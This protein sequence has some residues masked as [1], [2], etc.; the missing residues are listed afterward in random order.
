MAFTLPESVLERV[1]RRLGGRSCCVE[2]LDPART[3]LIV[4]DMQNY[5]VVPGFQ[6][7]CDDARGLV[8]PIHRLAGELR[9]C[10]GTVAWIQTAALPAEEGDWQALYDTYSPAA[11]E[12]RLRDL[13]EGAEGYAIWSE[14]QPNEGDIFVRKLRYSAFIQGASDLEARLRERGVDTVLISGVATNVCC[15]FDRA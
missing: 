10:G 4:V 15:E 3:A 13:A 6:A 1:R 5:F 9:G 8:E 2:S 14:M 7:C 11:R 12:A